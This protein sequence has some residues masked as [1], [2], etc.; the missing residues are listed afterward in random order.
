MRRSQA[1]RATDFVDRLP[2]KLSL[3]TACERMG[4]EVWSPADFIV[5]LE[6]GLA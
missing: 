6:G 3:K 2:A 1:Q 5:W 4:I